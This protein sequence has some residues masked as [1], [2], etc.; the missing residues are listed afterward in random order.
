[1]GLLYPTSCRA[2]HTN[3]PRPNR[4]KHL[5]GAFAWV[6]YKS[7]F[8]ARQQA[9]QERT[10]WFA[11]KGRAYNELQ[12]TKPQTLGYSLTDS[13]VGL[14]A[15]I[16]EKM[17]DWTD[18]YAW[19]ADE[20]LTWVSIYWFS[21]A[22]PAAAQRI[23][24][25]SHNDPDQMRGKINDYIPDVKLGISRFPKELIISPKEWQKTLGPVVLEREYDHGGHFAAWERPDALVDDLRMMFGRHGGAFGAV[26]GRNGF[27]D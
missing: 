2:S 12:S 11:E 27:E 4:P 22:G 10:E 21:T 25:E 7:K 3:F 14:L 24:Y 8:N 1:M 15:W 18:H 26:S 17:H 13:P 23:Y 9:D 20:I 16:Y 19:T 6:E 5:E